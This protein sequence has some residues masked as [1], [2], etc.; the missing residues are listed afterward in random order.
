MFGRLSHGLR[1]GPTTS[2]GACCRMQSLSPKSLRD[3]LRILACVLVLKVTVGVV[4]AYRDYLPP[5]F[6]SDFLQGRAEYFWDGYHWAFYTH[7]AS[8]PCSLMLG[9]IMLSNRFRR[10]FSK[11]HRRLGRVQVVCVLFLVTPSGLWMAFYAFTGTVACAG[12]ASVAV[13]TA[14]AICLGWRAAVRKRF[15]EHR[16]WMLRCYLMLC[17]AVVLRLTSGLFTVAGI[18]DEWTYSLAAWSSWLVPLGAFELL[19]LRRHVISPTHV[20][21]RDA[22]V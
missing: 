7:I 4:L 11:W 22:G 19:R 8:G 15:D 12:F 3:I 5:D 10:R 13:G 6:G 1:A 20:R 9:M 17:S 18:E 2:T 16:R 21:P 14:V